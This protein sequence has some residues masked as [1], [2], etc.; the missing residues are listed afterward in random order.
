METK[1]YTTKSAIDGLSLEVMVT[2]PEGEP[3]A[4]IQMCHGMAEHKERYEYVM[5]RLASHGFVCVM[6]DHR[7]HGNVSEEEKGY[8]GDETGAAIVKDTIQITDEIKKEYPDLPVV[9]YGH[10]MGSLVVRCVMKENDDAY[11]ALI[12]CGS[13]SKNPA[14]GAAFVLLKLLKL[15][16]GERYRSQFMN[17]MAFGSYL[18]GIENPKYAHAWI[19]SD[20]SVQEEYDKCDKCGFVFTINGF[21]NLM[22]LLKGCY[23]EKGWQMKNPKC[24]VFFIAG[25][26][27]PCITSIK[28]FYEAVDFMKKVGY[29]DVSSKLYPGVRHEIHNEPC[30]DQV[31]TDMAEFVSNLI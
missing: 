13:P 28:D 1:L 23:D 22:N 10:S 4:V 26:N 27:D 24:P 3:K 8:M 15:F 25:E 18:K 21:M 20:E 16:K 29:E 17:N 2:V 14:V 19:S 7:G 9:L 30:K 11:A 5:N 31:I 12:V 6:H